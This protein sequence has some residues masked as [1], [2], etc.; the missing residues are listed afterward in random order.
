MRMRTGATAGGWM[1]YIS[2]IC[3]CICLLTLPRLT[4]KA[5][6]TTTTTSSGS[7][8]ASRKSYQRVINPDAPS[9]RLC[10]LAPPTGRGPQPIAAPGHAAQTDQAGSP[11][12]PLRCRTRA[13]RV[14]LCGCK[15]CRYEQTD[16]GS[17]H[18]RHR[19]RGAER[20]GQGVVKGEQRARQKAHGRVCETHEAFTCSLTHLLTG[21]TVER[22]SRRLD[23]GQ[24]N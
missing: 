19:D 20:Q 23:P 10:S 2:R 16:G 12:G 8:I 24:A 9:P 21:V 1:I 17:S 4:Q 5:S 3:I 6:T 13:T 15:L 22:T 7:S 11:K 18:D 14:G